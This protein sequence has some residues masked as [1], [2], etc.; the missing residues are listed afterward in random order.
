MA[1]ETYLESDNYFHPK[2]QG[3]KEKCKL[4]CLKNLLYVT[5]SSKLIENTKAIFK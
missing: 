3:Q 2:L 1:C 5:K 4:N